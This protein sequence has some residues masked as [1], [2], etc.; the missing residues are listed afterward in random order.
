MDDIEKLALP[1]KNIIPDD[2]LFTAILGEKMALWQKL[3]DEVNKKY[4]GSAGTWNYYNDGHQWLFKMVYKKK[5]LFWVAMH[6]DSFRVTYYFGDKAEPV[7][8]A[9]DL[10]STVLENFKTA[11]RFGA[12]RAISTR[13]MNNDDLDLVL[14]LS[15]IKSRLK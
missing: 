10:P 5:T 9:S 8:N 7:L 4:A 2:K 1:D 13:V 12:I 6:S 11:K 14:K 3:L 15:E